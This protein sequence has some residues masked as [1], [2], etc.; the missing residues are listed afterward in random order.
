[1]GEERSGG[2]G[3]E[4]WGRSGEERNGEERRGEGW[5]GVKWCRGAEESS[6]VSITQRGRSSSNR[7]SGSAASDRFCHLLI[8]SHEE[9]CPPLPPLC[10]MD[11]REG[12]TA[13]LAASPASP[14]AR[15]LVLCHRRVLKEGAKR[16]EPVGRRRHA[17]PT[18][19]S[20]AS[21][22]AA[23]LRRLRG[24]GGRW[25][26]CEIEARLRGERDK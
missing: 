7:G 17:V 12:C 20:A 23:G 19:A 21:A 10:A 16:A 25:W 5:S 4:W 22:A 1:M 26:R 15:L 6:R 14:A 24:A 9:H 3:E 2:G 13:R 18:E 8:D 11:R